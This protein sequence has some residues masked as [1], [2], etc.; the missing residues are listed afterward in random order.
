MIIQ[1]KSLLLVWFLDVQNDC[2]KVFQDCPDEGRVSNF[3]MQMGILNN[4]GEVQTNVVQLDCSEERLAI[5]SKFKVMQGQWS[6][7]PPE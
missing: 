7:G 2:L 3:N 5:F 6:W 4:L 1:T